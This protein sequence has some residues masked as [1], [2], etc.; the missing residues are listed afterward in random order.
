MNGHFVQSML[1]Q[2]ESSELGM[3]S[4]WNISI[5]IF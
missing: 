1:G 4:D 2:V 3:Y 5:V